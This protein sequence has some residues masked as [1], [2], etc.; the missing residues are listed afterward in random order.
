MSF[1]KEYIEDL[2]ELVNLDAGTA[3]TAGVTQ[4][5][6]IM[7]RHFDSIG[8][9]C[10]L[11]DL[12]PRVGRG[13][14]ARN[15]PQANHYDVL[16]NAH[17]DTVFP[18]GTAAA[19]PFSIEGFLAH[20]PGCCDCKAGVLSI[21]YAL[22]LA[23]PE[24][25]ERL[26]I[27]VAYNPDEE[28]GSLFSN[29]WLTNLAAQSSCAL[30]CEGAR[31]NGELVR[32]RKGISIYTVKFIGRAAHAGN[33]PQDGRSA[34]LAAARFVLEADKL[35]NFEAGST[36][37]A[38]I[39]RAG[40]VSNVIPEHAYVEFDTRYWTNEEQVRQKEALKALAEKNWGEDI[41][42]TFEQSTFKPAMPLSE[43]TK[44]L[45]EKISQAATEVGFTARFVDAGGASDGN[46][47]ALM[48]TPV[49]DGCGPAGG[50]YHTDHEFL[51]LDTVEERTLMLKKF[52]ELI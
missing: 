28:T 46:N 43:A 11:V 50:D 12:G 4:A 26:S 9:Q 19:R 25:L 29:A 33:N 31:A 47:L 44:D 2:K 27:A 15:K 22:K 51:R 32:S 7:K 35:N 18:N 13:L 34:L 23:R 42:T 8:F 49:I 48:G 5:A 38:G 1:L 39:L 40:T 41:V 21:F 3:N 6:E 14:L 24:D 30:V 37:T 16:F 45:V 52:L 10:E 20:G 36:I 17:L